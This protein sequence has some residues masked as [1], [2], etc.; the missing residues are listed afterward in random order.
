MMTGLELATAANEQIDCVIVVCDNEAQGS[1]LNSQNERFGVGA[2]YG[3]K[4]PSPDFVALAAAHGIQGRRVLR[5]R[6]FAPALQQ[7]L[8]VP[9]P[10]LIHLVLDQR[11][12]IP[13]A[14]GP[15][16]V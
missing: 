15:D 16:A 7:A 10:S 1:I 11:D 5:T 13:F 8:D 9:G 3:T 14:G 2:D 12:I 4:L 6:E